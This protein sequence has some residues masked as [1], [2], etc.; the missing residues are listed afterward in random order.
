LQRPRWSSW[1]VLLC[2]NGND[3]DKLKPL[4]IGMS[5]RIVFRKFISSI[6]GKSRQ[7]VCFKDL[8]IANRTAWMNGNFFWM[9]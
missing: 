1:A 3:S 5:S 6:L 7:L 2:S 4:V 9:A 8:D